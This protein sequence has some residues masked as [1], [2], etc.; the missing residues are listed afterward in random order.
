MCGALGATHAARRMTIH[1]GTGD[2]LRMVNV[3][4]GKA[5]RRDAMAGFTRFGSLRM[6]QGFAD[7]YG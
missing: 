5:R 4:R 7:G 6:R 1:A 3:K 2:H